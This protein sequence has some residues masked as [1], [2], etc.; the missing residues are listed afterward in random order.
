MNRD[1]DTDIQKWKL[2]EILNTNVL[3][4]QN[5]LRMITDT[6]VVSIETLKS[7]AKLLVESDIV[8][9]TS[10]I[11]KISKIKYVVLLMMIRIKLVVI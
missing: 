3:C 6:P 5:T 7:V 8:N 9:L 2:V 10:S 1:Q 4:V 11:E